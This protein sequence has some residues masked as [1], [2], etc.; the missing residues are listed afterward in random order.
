[1]VVLTVRTKIVSLTFFDNV[2]N[3]WETMRWE[4]LRLTGTM[5]E[6]P[7]WYVVCEYYPPGNIVGDKNQY[8]KD[9]VPKQVKG[10]NSDTVESGISSDGT[11]WRDFRWSGGVFV[12]AG[13]VGVG[14]VI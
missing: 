11:S 9:N 10:R 1:M 13:L 3:I 14:F 2:L 8:F 5:T 7:G 6:T 4:Q 12:V